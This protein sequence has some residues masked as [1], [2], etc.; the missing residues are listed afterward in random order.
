MSSLPPTGNLVFRSLYCISTFH[1]L[2][3]TSKGELTSASGSCFV[4]VL[5]LCFTL[6]IVIELYLIIV[7]INNAMIISNSSS[8][9][10]NA[11]CSSGGSD[12]CFALLTFLEFKEDAFETA[13]S[14]K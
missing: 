10:L 2:T 14:L 12:V 1:N 6:K 4:V 8:K 11:L 7:M 3:I 13:F 9:N 5:Q